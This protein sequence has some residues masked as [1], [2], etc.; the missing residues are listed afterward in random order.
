MAKLVRDGAAQHKSAVAL[1]AAFALVGAAGVAGLESLVAAARIPRDMATFLEAQA[2]SLGDIHVRE[3]LE[4][5]WVAFPP[6]G[7]LRVFEP[8]RTL[9]RI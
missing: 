7:Y 8:R 4:A 9:A 2:S 3:L 1:P 6:C 5:N